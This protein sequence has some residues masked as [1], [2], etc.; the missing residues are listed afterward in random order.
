MDWAEALS[1]EGQES[2]RWTF[3]LMLRAARR[4]DLLSMPAGMLEELAEAIEHFEYLASGDDPSEQESPAPQWRA[5]L[6]LLS[7]CRREIRWLLPRLRR[8]AKTR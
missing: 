7:A 5:Q 6:D 4:P 2:E 1:P 8:D 3:D